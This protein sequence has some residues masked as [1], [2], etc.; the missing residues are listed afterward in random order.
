MRI[1][2]LSEKAP[3][4]DRVGVIASCQRVLNAA[5]DQPAPP[6]MHGKL[7][8]MAPQQRP[9][10]SEKI[11]P[12][13]SLQHL[14]PSM[15][16]DLTQLSAPSL[17]RA[18]APGRVAHAEPRMLMANEAAALVAVRE[19]S[20]EQQ[21]SAD[22]S[23]GV[24][25]A[26]YSHQVDRVQAEEDATQDTR[27]K[28]RELDVMELFVQLHDE[29]PVAAA[30]RTELDAR[31]FSPRQIEVGQHLVSH[32]AA[33]RLRWAEWLPGIRGVDA[34]FWLLRLSHDS[35]LQVRRAAVGLLATDRD[36]EVV[37]RLQQIAVAETD[38]RIR[39]EASRALEVLDQP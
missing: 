18:D 7:L 35:N 4:R 1:V 9:R 32:D 23:D 39:N 12:V 27:R 22:R 25:V 8:A 36:P 29:S 37:R 16:L 14:G 13:P 20:A 34:R 30:A 5:E 3:L 2:S 10:K 26:A 24:S 31:G 19:S 17:A 28:A 38:D 11:S 6:R 33:E 15:G 21:R